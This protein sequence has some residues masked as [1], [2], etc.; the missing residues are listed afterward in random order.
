[1]L[2]LAL[3]TKKSLHHVR[4]DKVVVPSQARE[5]EDLVNINQSIWQ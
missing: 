5:V 3:I 4:T 2:A 1:M